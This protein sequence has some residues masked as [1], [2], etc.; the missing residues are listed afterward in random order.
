MV[1]IF[2][3]VGLLISVFMSACSKSDSSKVATTGA[4][5]SA[6][7]VVTREKPLA[8]MASMS[9]KEK[10]ESLI[11]T[12]SHRYNDKGD[13]VFKACFRKVWDKCESGFF[14]QM[15]YDPFAKIYHVVPFK[16]LVRLLHKRGDG[17]DKDF[18]PVVFDAHLISSESQPSEIVI[19]VRIVNVVGVKSIRRIQVLLGEDVL[20]A[21]DF[22]EA[23]PG[24]VTGMPDLIILNDR[25]A[26]LFE[27]QPIAKMMGE[28]KVIR[29]RVFWRDDYV[30]A[31][32]LALQDLVDQLYGLVK[33]QKL[34]RQEF[35]Q[36][37]Q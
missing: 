18:G 19:Q 15:I 29:A 4:S 25:E 27:R 10:F 8:N 17:F 11:E 22:K 20:L 26:Q 36:Q 34:L 13:E 2:L 12:N 9:W 28:A 16:S 14:D 33:I 31:S 6:S 30:A 24:E 3:F 35:Q 5:A 37:S 21:R 7:S 32:D 1:R 23:N